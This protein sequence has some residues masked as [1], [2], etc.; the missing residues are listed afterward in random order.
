MGA[1]SVR[2]GLCPCKTAL[3]RVAHPAHPCASALSRAGSGVGKLL[4]VCE[5][6]PKSAK[7]ACTQ[8][9]A[10]ATGDSNQNFGA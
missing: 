10:F 7:T 8:E 1:V 6:T 4:T 3:H 5:G 9:A 2:F